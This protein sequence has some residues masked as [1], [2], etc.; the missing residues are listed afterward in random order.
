MSDELFQ[1]SLKNQN[2]VGLK[3][4][5]ISKL[6]YVAFFG[7]IIPTVALG[8]Q[9]AKWLRIDKKFINLMII[10]GGLV[11]FSK[12][13]AVG[14]VLAHYLEVSSR[15]IKLMYRVGSLLVY[16]GYSFIMRG[17]F[18][19]HNIIGG[20]YQP[21]LNDAIKWIII[22]I[23]IEFILLSIGGGIISIVL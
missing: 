12:V 7:G 4:Y 8:T 22:G 5:N 21:M 6:I 14:L 19:Q 20:S 15:T 2:Y 1:P 18:K 11:L 17:K 9:N 23:I 10:L 3:S 13:I 16:L